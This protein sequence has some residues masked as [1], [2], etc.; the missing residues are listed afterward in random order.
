[1]TF[2]E[3]II[4]LAELKK[5]ISIKAFG[6]WILAG[7]YAVLKKQRALAFP[8]FSRC[9]TLKFISHSTNVLKVKSSDPELSKAFL[10]VFYTGLYLLKKNTKNLAGGTV[11]LKSNIPPGAGLGSSSALCVLTARLFKHFGWI[12]KKE[13][14]FS[15]GLL[16]EKGLQKG[17]SSG[18]DIA[19]ILHEKPLLYKHSGSWKV[20][21]SLCRPY[22]FL[23]RS[24]VIR[25][26]ST[27]QN[28][29]KAQAFW[30]KK[31]KEEIFFHQQMKKAVDLASTCLKNKTLRLQKLA[32]SL[33]L[34]EEC[35]YKSRLAGQEMK[36]HIRFLKTAGALAVKPTG[37]GRTGYVLSL[38]AKKPPVKIRS[39]LI[40]AF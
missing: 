26:N 37:S 23:S 3:R 33:S 10:K 18:L 4:I 13:E 29:K 7:E 5:T 31:P 28:I 40:S 21:K 6:K 39:F 8:L 19:V 25:K 15:L 11:F 16:L 12:K 27:A 14:L 1:M 9:I 24:S 32:K 30:S 36:R 2:I 22:L 35:F 17:K 38:W 20:F 34:A